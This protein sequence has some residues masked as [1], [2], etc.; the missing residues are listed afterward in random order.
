MKLKRRY[1]LFFVFWAM[2]TFSIYMY[3]KIRTNQ[4]EENKQFTYG[5]IT[6]FDYVKSGAVVLKYKFLVRNKKYI[7]KDG[8]LIKESNYKYFEGKH[9]P[10]VYSKKDPNKNYILIFPYAFKASGIP[11]PDSLAWVKQYEK[12]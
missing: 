1:I 7:S 12:W 10:V 6:D 5:I 9:F 3:G 11:F 2:V 4:I 8:N